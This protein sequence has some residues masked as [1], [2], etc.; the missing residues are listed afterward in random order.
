MKKRLMLFSLISFSLLNSNSFAQL[1]MT[2]GEVYNYNVGDV[3]LVRSY[4]QYVAGSSSYNETDTIF[5]KTTI[6]NKYFSLNGDTVF[7]NSLI[8]TKDCQSFYPFG[9]APYYTVTY[10][11]HNDTSFYTDLQSPI[12]NYPFME[13]YPCYG[14]S[15]DSI[16]IQPNPYCS[17][18]IWHKEYIFGT[19]CF[20]EPFQIYD[21]AEGCG[22][23][24]FSYFSASSG[25]LFW[26]NLIYYKKGIDTCGANISFTTGV[27]ELS[28]LESVINIFP[29]PSDTFTIIA[30]SE[31][32]KQT[33]IIITDVLGK[34]IKKIN[35]TG[36]QLRIEKGEMQEGIYFVQITCEKK[37]FLNKIII[38]Q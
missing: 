33:S 11:T 34:E 1:T 7:Y 4:C 29:N 23:P 6:L 35:F 18:K 17:K 36:R 8:N 16:Y 26:R 19:N 28:N 21:Y 12:Q 3:F 30:F 14:D 13:T 22:G 20:E 31:Q 9:Q 25:C 5:E 15:I 32:Q 38:M 2:H 27:A 10:N 24:Y 37:N